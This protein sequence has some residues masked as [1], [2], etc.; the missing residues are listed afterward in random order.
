M[1]KIYRIARTE[2]QTLFY[3]PVAW[4]IIVIFTFQAATLYM[5]GFTAGI[6]TQTFGRS[7]DGITFGLFQHPWTGLFTAIQGYLYLY[8]PLLTMGLM[9]RELGS[10]SIK[11]L[12]SSPVTNTQI[13]LGKFLSMMI[14]G[15][16]LMAVLFV[17]VL[18]GAITI[19]D[20]DFP[21]VLT[22]MLGL[23]LLLCAYAAV[24]LFMSC[25]TS[26]QIVAAV[27]TLVMLGVLSYMKRLWQDIE[28]VREITYWLSISGR[29]SEFISGLLCSED[30]LYFII[31][32]L[33]F[34]TFTIIRLQSCRQKESWIVTLG[35]YLG[36]LFVVCFFGYLS[37]RPALMIYYDSTAT[38][39]NTLTKNS[40]EVISKLR[41]G[42]TITSY[43]NLLDVRD[44]WNVLPMNVKND[45]QR[46][47]Q[48]LRFK[49]EIKMKYVY[50]YDT[51][52]NPSFE[53]RYPG[54]N[55]KQ[56]A[57]ELI[58]A[59][60]LDSNLFITPE[61]IRRK[62]NLHSEGNRFVRL[63]ERESGEKTFLRVFDDMWHQPSEAEI[64][65]AFKRIVMELPQVG[66]LTGHG[67][68]DIK[69]E[70]D[71][72]YNMFTWEKP[73]R[74]SLINQGFEV[75]EV[76]LDEEI[77]TAVQI[78]VIAEMRR[79]LSETEKFNLDTYIARGGNLLIL[80]EPKRLEYMNPLLNKF[81]V[82]QIQGTLVHPSEG[83][84]PDLLSFS[85]TK[86][87]CEL[88]YP[89]AEMVN[90]N[91]VIVTPG[92]AGLNYQSVKEYKVTPLFTT[93]SLVWNEI[94]TTNFEDD[95]VTFN[96]KSGEI[97]QCYTI[98][99]ALS[100][101]TAGKE[102]RIVI[103][104]DADCISNGELNRQHKGI[105]ATNFNIIKGCFFWLSDNEVPIDVRRP[106]PPDNKIYMDEKGATMWKI[107]FT[108]VLPGLLILFYI[109][110]WIRRK[111][112]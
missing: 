39:I 76:T 49:P 29:A 54:L 50:Y 97:R 42:L 57:T 56:L 69:K 27:L 87:A 66:F 90:K 18:F 31:V 62:I 102:Q 11:L 2:L 103:W 30:V 92:V 35:K 53:K 12:Y 20:F 94:E 33:L 14:Y 36:T 5:G 109:L 91:K 19:K 99:L 80:T 68:R 4:L 84:A 108:W 28:L 83:H 40:Q 98:A 16:A 105:D 101:N 86:D 61:E 63:L 82:N 23:Y 38:K 72:D 64:T 93:D 24:G 110:L 45:Q 15:L 3:S 104:G 58:K 52:S 34:L 96:P 106:E 85:P 25:L 41:G 73:F 47:R 67:E 21:A 107:I 77:P 112:R 10:G 95:S 70:G 46:F 37:S 79:N 71:R 22:G 26:Y 75:K 111:G 13:V 55:T 48:Y 44:L 43:A 60:R 88:I 59:Y 9:S 65:A 89:F 8:I 78:L 1:R 32:V 7:I 6:Q 100:R 51:L 17:F 81:G 74:H